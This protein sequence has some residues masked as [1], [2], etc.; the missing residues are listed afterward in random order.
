MAIDG[1][2]HELLKAIRDGACH[3]QPD[4]ADGDL[5][6]LFERGFFV[7]IAET[8]VL[9]EKGCAVLATT[10]AEDSWAEDH[11]DRAARESGDDD[12]PPF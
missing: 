4:A 9:T 7:R 1:L 6:A 11:G 12:E 3:E 10:P 8:N 2:D 5:F